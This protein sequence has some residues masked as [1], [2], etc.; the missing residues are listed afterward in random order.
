[1]PTFYSV[2]GAMLSPEQISNRRA[3]DKG[4]DLVFKGKAD[5]VKRVVEL[6]GQAGKV[7]SQAQEKR[8]GEMRR[9]Q[10]DVL[11]VNLSKMP[12]VEKVV[13]PVEVIEPMVVETVAESEAAVAP[14]EVVEPEK[15]EPK[16]PAAKKK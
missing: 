4:E 2:G 14:V 7:T 11:M 5:M 3:A 9:D 10:L 1:M 12:E 6:R 8:Y 16:K 13:E 15:V